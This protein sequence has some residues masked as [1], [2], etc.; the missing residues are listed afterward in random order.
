MFSGG[1]D[2]RRRPAQ[3]RH[4]QAQRDQPAQRGGGQV[5]GQEMRAAQLLGWRAALDIVIAL[6]ALWPLWL[7]VVAA[8]VAWRRWRKTHPRPTAS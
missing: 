2:A 7:T 4:V 3:H 8:G 5:M 1:R 6:A